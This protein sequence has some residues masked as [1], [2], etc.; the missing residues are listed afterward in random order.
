MSVKGV[1]EMRVEEVFGDPNPTIY[2]GYRRGTQLPGWWYHPYGKTI[3]YLGNTSNAAFVMLDNIEQKEQ[4]VN[5]D[6]L[7]AEIEGRYGSH[8]QLFL[9]N[10]GEYAGTATVRT[11]DVVTILA[12]LNPGEPPLSFYNQDDT[13]DLICVQTL[14]QVRQLSDSLMNALDEMDDADEFGESLDMEEDTINAY[15]D[16]LKYVITATV[17]CM[18][19]DAREIARAEVFSWLNG[20]DR[21]SLEDYIQ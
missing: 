18:P 17:R 8:T 12:L 9:Q 3:L 13:P 15:L 11:A 21:Y 7:T 1:L 16:D 6:V 4:A 19:L 10:R 20:T 5:H 2:C 14:T